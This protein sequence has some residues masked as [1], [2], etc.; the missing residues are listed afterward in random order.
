MA[1]SKG[2]TAD[3]GG[4]SAANGC[5]HVGVAAPQLLAGPA[6][7]T[8]WGS[9]VAHESAMHVRFPSQGCLPLPPPACRRS[10]AACHLSLLAPPL[11]AARC[12]Y[13]PDPV[14]KPVSSAQ[15]K[16]D[17]SEVG[18]DGDQELWLLQLPLDVSS[19]ACSHVA[20]HLLDCRCGW[21]PHAAD[22]TCGILP[23]ASRPCCHRCC[24]RQT[25]SLRLRS[26]PLCPAVPRWCQRELDHL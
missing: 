1:G 4:S 2:A 13:E 23:L 12:R 9:R 11:S 24:C 5:V 8:R 21:V 15:P 3:A 18:L 19:C 17:C 25:L 7:A 6:Q 20:L 14:F 16:L 26:P 22:C 10:P